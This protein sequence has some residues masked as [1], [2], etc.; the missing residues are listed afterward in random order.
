MLRSVH[1][2]VQEAGN[3]L[4]LVGEMQLQSVLYGAAA[5]SSV[6]KDLLRYLHVHVLPKQSVNAMVVLKKMI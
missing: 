3:Y 1:A 4:Q 5:H 6:L 2:I